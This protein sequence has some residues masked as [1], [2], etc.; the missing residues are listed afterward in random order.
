MPLW[1]SIKAGAKKASDAAAVKAK[2]VKL[3]ADIVLTDREIVSRQRA[4]GVA[5]YDHVAPLSQSQE[6]YA[7]DDPL[8]SIIRPPLINAQKEIQALGKCRFLWCL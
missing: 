7:A 2:I 5:M 6:F 4:F 3:K 8:T 1:D